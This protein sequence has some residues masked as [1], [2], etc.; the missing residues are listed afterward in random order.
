M[1]CEALHSK[2]RAQANE[3]SVCGGIKLNLAFYFW[4][5]RQAAGWLSKTGRCLTFDNNAD[6]W[7]HGDAAVN[8]VVKTLLGTMM[9]ADREHLR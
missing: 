7:V 3:F 6:G 4:P 9:T 2:G 8:V 5:Q 1:G